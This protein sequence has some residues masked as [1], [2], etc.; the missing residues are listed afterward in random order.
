MT[1]GRKRNIEAVFLKNT[2][3]CWE[4]CWFGYCICIP[5]YACTCGWQNMRQSLWCWCA[6]AV[7]PWQ[8]D[9]CHMEHAYWNQ[10]GNIADLHI[11][12]CLQKEHSQGSLRMTRNSDRKNIIFFNLLLRLLLWVVVL[13][14]RLS[15]CLLWLSICLRLLGICLLLWLEP[16]RIAVIHLLFLWHDKYNKRRRNRSTSQE[17]WLLSEKDLREEENSKWWGQ[18]RT[19]TCCRYSKSP[20]RWEDEPLRLASAIC[21][22]FGR[23]RFWWSNRLQGFSLR[24]KE[25]RSRTVRANDAIIERI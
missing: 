16:T 12:I 6:D 8:A 22:S 9:P 21:L 1:R 11:S 14:L 4:Y 3:A 2:G 13:S 7:H 24:D 20:G 18:A 17:L 10:R 5:G 19:S 23:S 25:V 15:I